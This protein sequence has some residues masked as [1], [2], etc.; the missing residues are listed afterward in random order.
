[1]SKL[2]AVVSLTIDDCFAVHDIRIV[3]GAETVFVAMPSRKTPDGEFKD[4]VHPINSQAREEICSTI[5]AAYEEALKNKDA[6]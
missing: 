2:K 1:M 4:I 6:E 5:L 3:Q